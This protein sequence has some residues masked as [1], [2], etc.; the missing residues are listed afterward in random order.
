MA[1]EPESGMDVRNMLRG[2]WEC[3]EGGRIC[4]DGERVCR[5]AL[6][7]EGGSAGGI[8]GREGGLTGLTDM[9]RGQVER[10]RRYMD[11]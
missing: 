4:G 3:V 10:A 8:E 6:R 5:D 1:R 11:T 9:R 7:V 2:A